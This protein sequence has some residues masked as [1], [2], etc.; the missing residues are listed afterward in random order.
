MTTRRQKRDKRGLRVGGDPWS[1]DSGSEFETSSLSSS[2][3]ESM[4]SEELNLYDSRV[5]KCVCWP[6]TETRLLK[7]KHIRRFLGVKLDDKQVRALDRRVDEFQAAS[8]DIRE[9]II[10]GFLK[11][12]D[13][14]ST[15]L[16]T[17]RA[18]SAA[19]G[20]SQTFSSLFASTF[21]E[22]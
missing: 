18:P 4:V 11:S 5:A 19:L 15:G 7:L 9:L 1:D 21:T 3:Y 17:V 16:E 6:P 13:S 22:K 14:T 20:Y 2:G 12:F 8:Y 10:Q